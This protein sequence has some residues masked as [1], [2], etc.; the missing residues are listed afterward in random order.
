[1][2][3]KYNIYKIPI[4]RKVALIEKLE[5]V[6]L[7][8]VNSNTSNDFNCD[9]FLSN[10]PDPVDIWWIDLYKDFIGE[11]NGEFK[12]YLYFGVYL[13]YN[14]EILYG[15]SLGKS[16][17][18]LQSYCDMDFGL[19]FAARVINAE[20]IKLKN[21]KYFKSKKSKT[22][23]TYSEDQLSYDSA[24][25]IYMLKA[26]PEDKDTWGEIV[27]CGRSIQICV[28]NNPLE[29]TEIIS[30]IEATLLE[31]IK[32]NIPMVMPVKN[33]DEIDI[34]DGKLFNSLIQTTDAIIAIDEVQT[35][36]VTFVFAGQDNYQ[37]FLA[38]SNL[39]S[40]VLG[41]LNISD[42][43][44][45]FSANNINSDQ[46]SLI[47][48]RVI[49]E[50][51]RNYSVPIKKVLDYIDPNENYC[52]IEGEWNK[53]NEAYIEYLEKSVNEIDLEVHNK[54]LDFNS[55]E[56]EEK[57]NKRMS[58]EFGYKYMDKVLEDIKGKYKIELMDLYENGNLFFV[59]KG[60]TQK[61]SYCVDQA[62][63][64]LRYLTSNEVSGLM[65][66]N[67][68][69]LNKI[70]VWLLLHRKPVSKLSELGSLILLMKLSELR[71][72]CIDKGVALSVRLNYGKA[73]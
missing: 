62:V 71:R 8:K 46:F 55:G 30:K 49:R 63:N 15:V 6:G 36:G 42:I 26:S 60:T 23:T 51:G 3:N 13:I 9:F 54:D 20:T 12:N 4:D 16:H 50:E 70:T 5:S 37:I 11:N 29:L 32:V 31:P 38:K 48:V 66:Q 73:D 58:N 47:N 41:E 43:R 65:S 68:M 10:S 2:A 59:K 45:F 28:K 67:E 7:K 39:K 33:P 40:S 19:N 35:I 24:E 69:Q 34:L 14:N 53:F 56:I 21:S 57:F 27:S 25:S 61:S 44:N 64:A 72:Q 22:I 18:Y 17:F 52:L 1:M